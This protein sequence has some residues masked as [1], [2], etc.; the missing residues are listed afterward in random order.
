[1]HRWGGGGGGDIKWN[2]PQSNQ[3]WEQI[4][5]GWFGF[6]VIYNTSLQEAGVRNS[7]AQS[8]VI[9]LAEP[10]RLAVSSDWDE[11]RVWLVIDRKLESGWLL[12]YW[13]MIRIGKSSCTFQYCLSWIVMEIKWLNSIVRYLITFTKKFLYSDWLKGVQFYWIHRQKKIYSSEKNNF[14]S[15]KKKAIST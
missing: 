11:F 15:T 3:P 13:L 10:N 8:E 12:H 6:C 1:M 7:S 9:P 4:K 2:G 5:P 14:A